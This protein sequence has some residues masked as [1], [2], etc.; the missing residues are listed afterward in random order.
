MA[1]AEIIV[2]G[3]AETEL[4]AS[5]YNDV[6]TPSRDI[7]FFDRRFKGREHVLNL[8]A[9]LDGRPVGFSSGFE[10]K[11]DTWFNWLM[12]VLPDFRRAGIASQLIAAEQSWAA[13]NGYHFVRME[14]YNSHR[15]V[16]HLAITQGY[17]VVGVR[18]DNERQANLIIFEKDVTEQGFG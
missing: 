6:F 17:D 4:I 15:A 16:L 11:P 14:C 18:W 7:A 1:N 13:E 12:G 8:I 5:L 3:P 10:S 2:V 9:E